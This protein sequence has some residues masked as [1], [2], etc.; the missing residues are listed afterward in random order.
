MAVAP[1]VGGEAPPVVPAL[2]L[3]VD[4]TSRAQG[5]EAV[6]TAIA[7]RVHVAVEADDG[8]RFAEEPDLQRAVAELVDA[9]DRVP[10]ARECGRDVVEHLG[11]LAVPAAEVSIR[12]VEFTRSQ[13]P[14]A[15]TV[16]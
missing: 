5:R 15:L 8:P 12:A 16:C 7:V 14:R 2:E 10:A 4:D 9:R 11:I 1:S 13:R 3:A 6:G